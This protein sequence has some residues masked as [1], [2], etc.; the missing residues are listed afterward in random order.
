MLYLS[1]SMLKDLFACEKRGY[2]HQTVPEKAIL[3]D[4]LILGKLVHEAIEK[5]DG[6]QEAY[7]FV[8]KSWEGLKNKDVFLNR[9]IKPPK[10]VSKLL[11]GYYSEIVP[12]LGPKES[13]LIEYFFT[14]DHITST[15]PIKVVGKIDRLDVNNGGNVWDWKTKVSSPNTYELLDIQFQ[16]YAWAYLKMYQKLPKNVYYGH[17]MGGELYN[18]NIPKEGIRNVELLL[19]KAAKMVYNGLEARTTG[20]QCTRCMYRAVCMEEFLGE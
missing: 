16:I 14:L 4:E 10:D 5:Y 12:L 1:A 2:Y 9:K 8:T 13:S 19:D 17:L 6:F 20:Y 11:N 3:S 7:A 15:G 18:I